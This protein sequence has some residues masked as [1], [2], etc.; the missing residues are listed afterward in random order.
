MLWFYLFIFSIIIAAHFK[1][2]RFGWDLLCRQVWC[3]IHFWVS[4]FIH[5]MRKATKT[6]LIF[7][8]HFCRHVCEYCCLFQSLLPVS[9]LC[10]C[11]VSLFTWYILGFWHYWFLLVQSLQSLEALQDGEHEKQRRHFLYFLLHQVPVSNNFSVLTRQKACQVCIFLYNEITAILVCSHV[12]FCHQDCTYFY[13]L[14]VIIIYWKIVISDSPS[15]GTPRLCNES[16]MPPFR[17]CTHVVCAL[18]YVWFLL[19]YRKLVTFSEC[20]IFSL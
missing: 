8:S 10:F 1:V 17:V 15:C 11:F 19:T 6:F 20:E 4:V 2:A 9:I 16:T 12:S 18:V 14:I 13:R 5:E 3:G 7:F